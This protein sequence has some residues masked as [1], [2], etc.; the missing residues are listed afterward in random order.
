MKMLE[1]GVAAA[2][3][4][5]TGWERGR[6]GVQGVPGEHVLAHEAVSRHRVR[7][8]V[9]EAP[10]VPAVF[11]PDIRR[12]ARMVV[13][14]AFEHELRAVVDAPVQR[15]DA[16]IPVHKSTS[17]SGAQRRDNLIYALIY[18]VTPRPPRPP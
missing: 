2:A 6:A 4:V 8:D 16:S 1:R 13:G 15:D 11:A 7:E 10:D 5:N 3:R 17:E 18:T 12:A 9:E 14:A